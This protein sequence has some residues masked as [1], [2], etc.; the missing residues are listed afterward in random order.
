MCH[1]IYWTREKCNRSV[2]SDSSWS[3]KQLQTSCNSLKQ[4]LRARGEFYFCVCVCVVRSFVLAFSWI[5]LINSEKWNV[6]IA[7]HGA[8]AII[9]TSAV[10]LSH[11]R[12]ILFQQ[13]YI[14]FNLNQKKR[15]D[16]KTWN[17]RNND[18]RKKNENGKPEN[19]KE[20]F[21][22]IIKQVQRIEIAVARARNW[23]KLNNE[24]KRRRK[25]TRR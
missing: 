13:L 10:H 3:Q 1:Y 24:R 22:T 6:I 14:N 23:S 19:E 17:E 5:K 8:R 12:W 15:E 9:V 16:L 21:Y 20:T 25:N 11:C 7:I 18:S 2:W 4:A